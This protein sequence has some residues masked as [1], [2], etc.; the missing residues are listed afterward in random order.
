MVQA[1]SPHVE[2]SWDRAAE[3]AGKEHRLRAFLE[4]EN[5]DGILIGTQRNFA[6]LTAGG[7]SHVVYNTEE[8]AA[9]L[10]WTLDKKYVIAANN[11][12]E[13][14]MTEELSDLGYEPVE[15]AWHS[16]ISDGA[17]DRLI[18]E[19]TEGKR[20][21]GDLIKVPAGIIDISKKFAF[22]RQQL[23]PEELNRY[24]W[25][26]LT[27]AE[28]VES[29]ARATS[30][31]QTERE[32]Q[33][34]VAKKLFGKDIIPTVL[35]VAADERIR[36]FKHPITKSAPIYREAMITLCARRWGLVVAVT[37]HVYFGELSSA[38]RMKQASLGGV[39]AAMLGATRP[40]NE[41]GGIVSAAQDAYKN[42][43]Y[44]SSWKLHHLGGAIG[45]REREYKAA[46]RSVQVV[47]DRQA[48]AWNP[49]LLGVKAE[50]TIFVQGDHIEIL[51][52]TGNWPRT[53]FE[54]GGRTSRIPQILT[55]P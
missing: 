35:M 40:G 21:G 44:P 47:L 43:G 29:V 19:L 25:L 16:G 12:M 4:A 7:D 46:P 38:M 22:L 31:G 51:T 23:T 6:W 9:L 8:G 41:S 24:R 42:E 26:A 13:R 34:E 18:R 3:I 1:E 33:T 49:T 15:F 55:L 45:Y 20:I 32:L 17:R 36:K 54:A 52:D 14:F 30:P 5:L 37:R 50:D 39:A 2:P 28:I 48:F 53:D 27:A 10:L 11:E